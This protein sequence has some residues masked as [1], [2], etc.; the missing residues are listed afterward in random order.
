MTVRRI[1][2]MRVRYPGP[3]SRSHCKISGSS[4][5]LCGD[6]LRLLN[7]KIPVVQLAESVVRIDRAVLD[8][9]IR[10][11][12]SHAGVQPPDRHT[13]I[14]PN[15]PGTLFRRPSFAQSEQLALAQCLFFSIS[16]RITFE[17]GSA[18]T[19]AAVLIK[20]KPIVLPAIGAVFP[21]VPLQSILYHTAYYIGARVWHLACFRIGN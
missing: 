10:G 12:V 16:G 17:P 8:E 19:R 6:G 20:V 13:K 3:K 7:L 4:R 2:L 11:F 18:N 14:R 1:S 9:R 15:S 5:T 21:C